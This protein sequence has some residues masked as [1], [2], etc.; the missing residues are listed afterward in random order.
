MAGLVGHEDVTG[1]LM[2]MLDDADKS[3]F[4]GVM[5]AAQEAGKAGQI[6]IQDTIDSTPSSLSPGKPDRNWTHKMRNSAAWDVEMTG[7]IITVRAGWLVE[8]EGYFLIQE[9]GG[10]VDG[11]TVTPMRALMNAYFIMTQHLTQ[12]GVKVL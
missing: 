12:A 1:G 5:K 7:D 6:A 9:H 2:K 3:A 8:K 10:L 4:V 11:K